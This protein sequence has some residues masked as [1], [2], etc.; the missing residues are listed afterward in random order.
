[1]KTQ[2]WKPWGWSKLVGYANA[3]KSSKRKLEVTSIEEREVDG[4][5]DSR[6]SSNRKSL[7]VGTSPEGHGS[8]QKYFTQEAL[9]ELVLPCID[10]SSS[11]FRFVFAGDLIK[12]MGVISEHIKAA[13]WNGINKL[14][15]SNPSG[16]EGLSK[17]NGRKGI[18][19]GS[20]NIRKHSPVPND[21]T[22]P[23]ASALRSSIWLR[24]QFII[25]LLPVIIAD[26]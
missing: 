25:R 9:A 10:R 23:S 16:N 3:N 19:S 1:M 13:V 11:E 7:N 20:P 12:H 26:R 24:L 6:K 8:T 14:N 17:P 18:F 21:S 4:L 5:I 22:T 2:F 15:S